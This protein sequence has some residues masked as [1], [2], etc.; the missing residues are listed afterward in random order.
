MSLCRRIFRRNGIHSD[1]VRVRLSHTLIDEIIEA[2]NRKGVPTDEFVMHAL[3]VPFK[4]HGDNAAEKLHQA[5]VQA[6]MDYGISFDCYVERV[7][8]NAVLHVQ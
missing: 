7:L 2:S 3:N 4:I 6:A 8:S 1:T 5:T